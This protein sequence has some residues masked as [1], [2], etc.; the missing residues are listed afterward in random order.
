LDLQRAQENGQDQPGKVVEHYFQEYFEGLHRYAFTI[1]KDSEEARDAVQAV[2][3]KLWEKRAMIDEG[4]SVKSY[5]YTSVY[6]HCLN[7]KRHTKVK[8]E[9]L[10]TRTGT[11]QERTDHLVSKE[12]SRQIIRHLESLP[13]QCKLI[14]FMSR[15]EE[16]KYA[17]IAKELGL[18]VKT[19]EAQIG[20]AL[21]L[22][23]KML[24]NI[25]AT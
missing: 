23:R 25:A 21:T 3:L 19:V 16:K 2:F 20:K 12:T 15:F 18:S 22:L 7:I 4:Q 8:K 10:S 11:D 5:L 24:N 6:H 9:Y 14:F 13:P 17:D 1:L